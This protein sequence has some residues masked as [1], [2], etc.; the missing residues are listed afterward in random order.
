[1]TPRVLLASCAELP[2]S[3]G[4]DTSLPAAL[5]ELGVSAGWAPWD[6][7]AADFAGADLVVLRATWDYPARRAE[8]LKW[9]ESVPNLAN[10][11]E[12]VRWNT[13]KRYLVDLAA[14]G[15]D[16]VPTQLVAPGA[17]PDW[18]D[19]GFVL[20]PSVGAGSVGAARFGPG[21]LDVAR[22]HLDGLHAD[23]HVAVLQPYQETV[24]REGETALVFVGG[25]YSHAFVKGAM[26]SD[27]AE[28]DGS[29]L[30][31][32]EQLWPADP[33]PALRR[34]AED[35]MDAAGTVLG[36]DRRELLYARVDL[37]RGPDGRPLL[38]ELELA[39]PSLGFRQTDGGARLRFAS[40][41]RAA[42]LQR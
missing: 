32:D 22:E 31:V 26:L 41:V 20:K 40:A 11:A 5:G 35:A 19:A 14:C 18:P 7:P 1:M 23:S 38:L 36:V 33:E 30:Y 2:E 12:V 13:D 6:D 9:C 24:D 25:T 8:F 28:L 16:V 10:P 3:D 21:S 15:L 42:L 29:G 17:Q 37:V 39:E 34:A 27:S 4:D